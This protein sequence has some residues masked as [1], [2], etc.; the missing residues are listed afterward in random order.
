MTADA[1]VDERSGTKRAIMEAT[2][3]ALGKYGYADL[4][5]Q[6]I[7]DEFEKSKSLLY[8]HYDTK[9]EL[10]IDVLRDGL[11]RF[12]AKNAVDPE[13]T[14]TEQLE[15]F[16]DRSLPATLD[17]ETRAFRLT[18]FE[19]RS[20]AP[21]NDAYREQFERADRLFDELLV[22]IL[23][24]GIEAG[25]FREVDVEYTADLLLSLVEGGMTRH[26]VT[27]DDTTVNTRRTVDT[28]LETNLLAR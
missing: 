14:A 4:T 25:E 12:A 3:S 28:Y 15:T 10:L 5:I 7:A 9:D 21:T 13:H 20:Q 22:D 1:G 19:L 18:I 16:L 24:R 2:A 11:D 23:E 26:L 6:A 17:E 27:T 8:Y